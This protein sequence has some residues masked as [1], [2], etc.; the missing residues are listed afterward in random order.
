MSIQQE[1]KEKLP[2]YY[3]PNKTPKQNIEQCVRGILYA[4]GEDVDR[5]GLIETPH[6]VAKMYLNETLFSTTKTND[7]ICSA[8]SKIFTEEEFDGEKFGDMVIVKD[9][10]FFSTCEHHIM[11]FF[12]KVSVGYI[13]SDKV[14]GLSKIARLVE[15]LSKRPQLQER[16]GKDIA[17]CMEK[18]LS[19]KGVMVV[20]EGSHTCMT[21]RGIK[22]R[23]SVTKTATIRGKFKDN[24]A[25]REEAYNLFS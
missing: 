12:G 19:P 21:A 6:R 17:D 8:V 4:I 14:I 7:E 9:I 13:P 23:G 16:L 3:D 24:M 15:V 5:E 25:L 1:S 20:I 10:T 22:S 2:F 18:M 11:P